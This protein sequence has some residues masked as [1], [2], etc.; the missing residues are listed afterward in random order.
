M[1]AVDEYLEHPMR[2]VRDPGER[3]IDALREDANESTMTSRQGKIQ[4]RDEG[5][6]RPE[7]EQDE[8]PAPGRWARPDVHRIVRFSPRLAPS[9][10]GDHDPR[11]HECRAERRH[12]GA[13]HGGEKDQ[14]H[15]GGKAF[16][17][18]RRANQ[19]ADRNQSQ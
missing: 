9:I 3:L 19:Q 12:L 17:A 5:D 8:A 14:R 13:K 15:G 1:L 18:A 4:D 16:D 7:R 2:N 11:H 10:D 6:G